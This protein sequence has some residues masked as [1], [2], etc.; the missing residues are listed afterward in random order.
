VWL[1]VEEGGA[2]PAS[3][4]GTATVFEATVSWQLRQGDRVVE[5]GFAT[6]TEGA[7][8]RGSWTARADVPPGDYA[9]H[10]FE[11]S[12]EDGSAVWLDTKRVRV[13]R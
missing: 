13:S 2:L 9:L 1:D 11:S 8:G 7:P 6:A 12:A 4:G 5:E 10:A 3:F